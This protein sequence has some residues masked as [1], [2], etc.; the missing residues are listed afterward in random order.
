L[1]DP[2]VTPPL[3]VAV[4]PESAAIVFSVLLLVTVDESLSV[5]LPDPNP[6]PVRTGAEGAMLAPVGS[7][8]PQAALASAA[9]IPRM[10]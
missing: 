7:W 8:E 6:I 5:M 2:N 1:P 9:A 10:R 4:D 3:L